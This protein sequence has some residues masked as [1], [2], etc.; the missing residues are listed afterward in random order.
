M[1]NKKGKTVLVIDSSGRGAAL[2][3]KYSQSLHVSKII[4]IP[5]NEM[6]QINSK[7]PVKIFSK[8]KTTSVSEIVEI[9][10]KEKVYLA[11]VAQDNAVE[12]GVADALLAEGFQVIGPT[13]NAGRLEWDKAWSRDFMKKNKLPIPS[14]QIFSSEKEAVLFV[15]KFPKKKWFI[16]ASGLAEGK[17]AIPAANLKEALFAIS[18]MKKFKE[19]GKT[20]VIEEWLDGEE[21]SLFA[22]SDGSKFLVAG[23]AQDHKRLLDGDKGPNTG[24]MG[25]STPPLVV[26][27]DIYAQGKKIIEKTLL[28]LQKEKTPYKGVLYLG[29]IV[30]KGKVYIIEFNARW[31]SPEAEVLIPGIQDDL[32]E[33]GVEIANGKLKRTVLKTDGKSRVV[34][35][36]SLRPGVEPQK[37]ELFGLEALLKNKEVIFYGTRV[38][39]EKNKFFVSSGRLFHLVADG[40]NVLEAR[41]KAYDFMSTLFIEGNNLHFRTDIGWRDVERIY[42]KK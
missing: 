24:G 28:G 25:C 4:A 20:F 40:K 19:S 13:K 14:Y 9:A 21:F 18:E 3:H 12:A 37:R 2:V 41:K 16:K 10:K 35:T 7:V 36:G 22:L 1:K 17:G 26:T 27:K 34:V 29:A 32:F 30:V 39:K 31:G 11:D 38:T 33:L 6:M 23:C 5:G 15:K 42:K 8:L